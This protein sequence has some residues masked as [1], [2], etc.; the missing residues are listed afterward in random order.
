M[1]RDHIFKVVM[2]SALVGVS[3]GARSVQAQ[4]RLQLQ[5]TPVATAV[6]AT[7]TPAQTPEEKIF[8]KSGTLASSGVSLTGGASGDWVDPDL[9]GDKLPPLS[10]T[11]AK[12]SASEWKLEV[13]NNLAKLVSAEIELVIT[14][15]DGKKL[16]TEHYSFSL[17][18][19]GA[20]LRV[21]SIPPNGAGYKVNLQSWK[22]S[23]PRTKAT[24][25]GTP[26]PPALTKPLVPG[27]P[28]LA[29]TFTP[30]PRPL[31]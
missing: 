1:I 22:T 30:F 26:G 21:V 10:A 18:A 12:S 17:P 8:P 13:K 23:V 29:P 27:V 28:T 25:A 3:P 15:I 4:Q 11:I 2:V 9:Q 20:G 5:Q 6:I 14:T 31:R 24:P 16:K 19:K 7:P